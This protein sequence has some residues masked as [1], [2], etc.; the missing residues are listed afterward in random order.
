MVTSSL[1]R[2]P[3]SATDIA[4]NGAPKADDDGLLYRPAFADEGLRYS[5]IPEERERGMVKGYV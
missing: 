2:D 4:P 1:V 3:R 5:D